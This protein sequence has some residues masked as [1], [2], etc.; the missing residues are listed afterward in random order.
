VSIKAA[1]YQ[2]DGFLRAMTCSS[3]P[4]AMAAWLDRRPEGCKYIGVNGLGIENPE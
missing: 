3:A 1:G 4:D 2:A